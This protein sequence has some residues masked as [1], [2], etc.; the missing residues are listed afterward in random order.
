MVIMILNQVKVFDEEI[1]TAG[2]VAQQFTDLRQRVEV[3]LSPSRVTS[4]TLAGATISSKPLRPTVRR[5]FV[6][7]APPTFLSVQTEAQRKI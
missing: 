4:R 3:E 1:V 2:T 6:L 5:P 7:H